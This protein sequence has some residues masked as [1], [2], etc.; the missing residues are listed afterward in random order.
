MNRAHNSEQATRCMELLPAAGFHNYS[1]DLIYG[2]PLLS[3]EMWQHNVQTALRYGAPHLSCYALTVEEKTPLHR[4]IRTQQ[5]KPVDPDKGAAQFTLLMQWLRAAGYEHYEVSNFAKP[6]LRSRH[7]SAYWKGIAYLGLGPS[8]HS[9][10][11]N[12]RQW[13]VAN[14]RQYVKAV[15]QGTLPVE[16]EVL[17]TSNLLNEYIMISLRTAE[18]ISLQHIEDVWGRETKELLSRQIPAYI[19]RGL[20]K[21]TEKGVQLT[22]EGM[23]MADGIAA[24]LFSS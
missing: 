5:T 12:S 19:N 18:G 24:Q 20:I 6:G 10:T 13:N 11:G 23:L 21:P 9:Y 17:T 4:S 8:A 7:N 22:D 3:N 2:S 15:M 16:T 1:I 14:N